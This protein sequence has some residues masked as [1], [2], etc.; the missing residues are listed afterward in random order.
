MSPINFPPPV[1][2]VHRIQAMH[3]SGASASAV[4]VLNP[5]ATGDSREMRMA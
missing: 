2:I 5:W 1:E 4:A 3:G